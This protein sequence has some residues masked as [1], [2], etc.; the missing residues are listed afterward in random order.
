MKVCYIFLLCCQ[1]LLVCHL[2]RVLFIAVNAVTG[3]VLLPS[4]SITAV[5]LRS[6]KWIIN[7]ISLIHWTDF[8][9]D[10][11]EWAGYFLFCLFTVEQSH[12]IVVLTV[13]FRREM[14]SA[15]EQEQKIIYQPRCTTEYSC[16]LGSYMSLFNYELTKAGW[17]LNFNW[18]RVKTFQSS[19]CS[20]PV[21]AEL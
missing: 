17:M 10:T 12:Q 20:L 4:T 18:D 8:A 11:S 3:T 1:T 7:F 14:L 16:R 2:L 5:L 15:W 21:D 6:S 13:T 19:V 9:S